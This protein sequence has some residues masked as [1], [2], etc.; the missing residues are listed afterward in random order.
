[1]ADKIRRD[2][3]K[4]TGAAWKSEDAGPNRD[5]RW[6]M[7]LPDEEL[8]KLGYTVDKWRPQVA[9]KLREKAATYAHCMEVA[10]Y[11]TWIVYQMPD[12]PKISQE[13][14][15]YLEAYY[16][17]MQ[18][19]STNCMVCQAPLSFELFARAARG[20]AAIETGHSNPRLHRA[21]N[22]GFAHRECNI[23]QG[24]KTLAEFYDWIKEI[25]GRVG[26]G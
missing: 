14:K 19:G 16:G 7:L 25:L 24:S 11:L 22:V 4:T 6:T 20:K 13:L 21:E 5:E 1:V 8:R 9:A 12:A 17:E 23:A 18:P 3:T 15:A 10:K 2:A 26:Q